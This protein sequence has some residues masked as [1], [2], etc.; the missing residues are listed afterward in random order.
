[1]G[2]SILYLIL[3]LISIFFKP[4]LFVYWFIL[5][6]II[7]PVIV[8]YI[9]NIPDPQ[10][11]IFRLGE[12]PFRIINELA[13]IILTIV[14]PVRN[15]FNWN[16]NVPKYFKGSI[17]YMHKFVWILLLGA[18]VQAFYF[19][20]FI[21]PFIKSIGYMILPL[22]IVNLLYFFPTRK[23]TKQIYYFSFFSML[24]IFVLF[25]YYRVLPYFQTFGGINYDN[26]LEGYLDFGANGTAAFLGMFFFMVINIVTRSKLLFVKSLYLVVS[27]IILVCL[28]FTFTKAIFLALLLAFLFNIVVEGKI[29]MGTFLILIISAWFLF[30]FSA[31]V[32]D[33][34]T[35]GDGSDVYVVRE[36]SSDSFSYRIYRLWI[37]TVVYVFSDYVYFFIGTEFSGFNEFLEN[38]TGLNHANHN[39]F[40]EHIAMWG[41]VITLLLTLFWYYIFRGFYKS[42]INMPNIANRRELKLCASSV[43]VF[44]ISINSMATFQTVFLIQIAIIIRYSLSVASKSYEN[45]EFPLNDIGNGI[46][47][48]PPN[49]MI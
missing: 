13:L 19:L 43:I 39:V 12:V 37:P 30:S 49:K 34:V 38:I 42:I 9:L 11:F 23:Q 29:R 4:K 14:Y 41:L 27:F 48:Y 26:R 22:F 2:L 47:Y 46:K 8:A 40:I 5:V 35:R 16:G 45:N 18:F 32:I 24:V 21:N 20:D 36:G 7:E 3:L 17:F 10:T 33:I 28:I 15:S 25:I 31:E 1:M 44:F 6:I